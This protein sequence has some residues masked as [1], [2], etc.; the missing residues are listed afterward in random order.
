MTKEAIL[1]PS[2]DRVK[3]DMRMPQLLVKRVKEMSEVLGVP[4]NALYA[5]GV[6]LL[7]VTMVP[8]VHPGKKRIQMLRELGELFR[9]VISGAEKTA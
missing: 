2:A 5:M 8:M 9:N 3:T 6:A 7:L 1:G 4:Q